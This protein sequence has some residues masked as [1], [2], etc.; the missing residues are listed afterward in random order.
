MQSA[1]DS[2]AGAG[3]WHAAVA[4]CQLEVQSVMPGGHVTEVTAIDL[5]SEIC[6]LIFKL[7]ASSI[8]K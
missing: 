8:A 6:K 4:D 5:V 1:R 7:F 2:D 3:H